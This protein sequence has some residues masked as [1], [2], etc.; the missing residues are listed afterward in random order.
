MRDPH[1]IGRLA[2]EV[3]RVRDLIAGRKDP[4]HL[5]GIG[6]V[7]VAGVA[8]M[9]RARGLRVSGCDGARSNITDWLQQNG[10]P[11][12][13]GHSPQHVV[14][15]GLSRD[16]LQPEDSRHKA[17][18]TK[19][20]WIVR[21]PAVRDSEEEIRAANAA[22]IPIF[23]RGVV[24]PALLAGQ[25]SVAVS[26]SHGKTTTTAMIAHVLRTCGVDASFCV[27]GIVDETGC[28]A[29]VG[30]DAVMVVEADESDGT[31]ALYSPDIAVITNIELDHVDFFQSETEL[32]D[33]FQKFGR[34]SG[35]I[36]FCADDPGARAVFENFPNAESFGF[37][38][39]TSRAANVIES[40]FAISFDVLCDGKPMGRVELGVPGRH[41]VLNALAAIAT[42][43][44]FEIPFGKIAS[45][46]L[47]FRPVRRRYEILARTEKRIV[48]SDYAHHPTE[49]R[50]LMK[51]AE[52]LPYKR[53]LAVFQP[54]RY[55][56]TAAFG[57]DFAR[58]FGGVDHLVLAPTYAAFEDPVPGGDSS[59][60][61][62]LFEQAN[63]VS[64]CCADSLLAAW[65]H[66]RDKWRDGD[67][68]LIVGAGDVEKI[69]FWA[70]DFL[71]KQTT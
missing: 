4:V 44:R 40:P 10:I 6:G 13:I 63:H 35:S 8:L 70:R 27:G 26:G 56:R 5:L 71:T 32:H 51:Q 65:E 55:T 16:L 7:G 18:P 41:N 12:S 60:L 62:R 15:A 20:A 45:S 57:A 1:K 61:A 64:S 30:R 46:L 58:S 69:G 21:S 28:V 68:L 50:A 47:T 48:I 17:A 59:D 31:V 52:M 49:I 29:S 19:P 38:G 11:V 24:L 33:C 3:L 37:D 39:G 67:A 2:G 42:A 43:S 23:P 66:I 22:D 54:H 53:I 36:I 34:Q 14:G 25:R 9:L